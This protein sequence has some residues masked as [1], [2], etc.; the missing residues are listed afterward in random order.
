MKILVTGS[1]GRLGSYLVP[2][3]EK[4]G[5]E[6]IKTGRRKHADIIYPVT[7]EKCDLVVHLAAYTDVVRAEKEPQRCFDTNVKGTLNLVLAYKDTPFFFV[8]TEYANNPLGIYALSK[9]L[10]EEVVNT[11]PCHYV[12]RTSF[13]P[14]PWPF[15]VA[16]KDQY[17][18]GDYVDVI[19]NLMADHIEHWFIAPGGMVKN[20]FVMVGTGRK[21]M[22][23]LAK[24]TRPD[25]KPNSV[26]EY[27][28]QIGATLIPKD[29]Q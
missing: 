1:T 21:T 12:A 11:H 23:D 14:T 25:V 20:A 13:K 15:E 22:F 19:A 8:S 24:R 29:Y 3:L 18:I 26:D 17:T 9:Y 10:A 7:P 16:Y 27:N 6:I 4:R 28:K 5:H 2:E